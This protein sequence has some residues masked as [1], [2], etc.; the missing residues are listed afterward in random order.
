MLDRG[1]VPEQTEQNTTTED[2][3]ITVYAS[4]ASG[5]RHCSDRECL[6]YEREYL[7]LHVFANSYV[8][9]NTLISEDRVRKVC[10]RDHSLHDFEREEESQ[11]EEE[12]Q[13]LMQGSTEQEKDREQEE[14]EEDQ[15]P[16]QEVSKS[17]NVTEQKEEDPNVATLARRL[18]PQ[19]CAHRDPD[20][21]VQHGECLSHV[22]RTG[23]ELSSDPGRSSSSEVDVSGNK[24]QDQGAVGARSAEGP[25][26]EQQLH[27]GGDGA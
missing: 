22:Q 5:E 18:P 3:N 8:G 12:R 7:P 2:L 13:L 1:G 24:V 15:E 17:S 19:V 26:R 14:H 20:P 6:E 4:L 9:C 10:V 23:Q 25:G 21:A 11:R 16:A 27:Q